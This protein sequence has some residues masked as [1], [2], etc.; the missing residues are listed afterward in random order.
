V[1]FDPDYEWS[2]GVK[3]VITKCLDKNPETRITIRDL[4]EHPWLT[5]NGQEPLDNVY[6][7]EEFW[8]VEEDDMPPAFVNSIVID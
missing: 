5:N 7:E 4:M 8:I 6:G 2:E 1:V 3:D